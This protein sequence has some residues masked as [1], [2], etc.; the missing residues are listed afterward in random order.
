M[1]N[2]TAD[3]IM[4]G[5]KALGGGVHEAGK[6]RIEELIA[7]QGYVAYRN[8]DAAELFKNDKEH[9]N[10]I[11]EYTDGEYRFYPPKQE[12]KEENKEEN[13]DFLNDYKNM[14]SDSLNSTCINIEFLNNQECKYSLIVI[15]RSSGERKVLD[16]KIVKLDNK[17]LYET[18]PSLYNQLCQGLP[19]IDYEKDRIINFT[20]VDGNHS[21]M[22]GNL[23]EENKEFIKNMK[24]FIDEKMG[25]N[26][27]SNG[28]GR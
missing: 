21:M 11:C 2:Q 25:Y 1:K 22:F 28:K 5:F 4:K 12:L 27:Y 7:K 17:F 19:I 23:T 13:I 3:D 24:S 16:E 20:S 26:I 8:K 14:K 6:R 15:N 10:W 9:E 18:L